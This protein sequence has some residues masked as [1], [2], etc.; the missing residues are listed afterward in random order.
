M[1]RHG[2]GQGRTDNVSQQPLPDAYHRRRLGGLLYTVR[3]VEA[4]VHPEDLHIVDSVGGFGGTWYWNRN[5]GLTYDI[6]SYSYLPLPEETGY[7]PRHRY[8]YD[9]EIR[10]YAK[11]VAE[12][13]GMADSAVFTTKAQKLVW[14]EAAKDWYVE[15]VPQRKREPPQTLNIRSHFVAT[16]NDM[17]N[18]PKLPGFPEF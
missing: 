10:S 6:E 13:R 7:M 11:I 15:L 12:K 4:G 5:P 18:W 8:A 17:L 14:D 9:E 16:V 3:M 2:Y 1:D